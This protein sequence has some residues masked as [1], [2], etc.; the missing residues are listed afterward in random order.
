MKYSEIKE[1]YEMIE[2]WSQ[3]ANYT[4]DRMVR[5]NGISFRG[6][7]SGGGPELRKELMQAFKSNKPWVNNASCSTSMKLSV[8]EQ[9]DGGVIL[10]HNKTGAYI[11]DISDYSTEYEIMTLRGSRYKVITPPKKVNGRYYVELE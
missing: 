2:E 9:F 3:G 7:N 8:A 6:L 1:Q 11:H 4:L 5:Y 10:I